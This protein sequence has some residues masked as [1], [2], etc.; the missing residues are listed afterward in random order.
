L[1]VVIV[2]KLSVLRVFKVENEF[3]ALAFSTHYGLTRSLILSNLVRRH[4]FLLIQPNLTPLLLAHRV[5]LSNAKFH[6]ITSG[7]VALNLH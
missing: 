4:S 3:G 1:L 7:L 6:D 2:L 5:R